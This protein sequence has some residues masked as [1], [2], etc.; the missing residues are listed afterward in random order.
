MHEV[1]IT[2]VGNVV[3]EPQ[4]TSTASGAT[5][6]T[7]RLASAERHYDRQHGQTRSGDSL[8]LHVRCWRGLALNASSLPKG[9]PVIVQGRLR[10]RSV[11]VDGPQGPQ[12]RTFVD[13]DALSLGIDLARAVLPATGA[14]TEEAAVGAAA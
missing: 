11:V 7:F 3:T 2:V 10:Q 12:R 8:L 14:V 1:V 9:A 13:L 6:T 4:T 5:L